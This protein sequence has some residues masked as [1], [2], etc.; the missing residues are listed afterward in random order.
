M[1]EVRS[2]KWIFGLIVGAMAGVGVV[3]KAQQ[4]PVMP[5]AVRAAADAISAEQL[6]WDLAVLAGDDNR[7]RNTPSP[8][9]DAAAD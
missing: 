7:G 8:G 5:P 9:F 3:T 6:A 1:S 2:Q 4:A